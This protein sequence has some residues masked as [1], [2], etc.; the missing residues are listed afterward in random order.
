M[1]AIAIYLLL[2]AGFVIHDVNLCVSQIVEVSAYNTILLLS[3]TT[4][5]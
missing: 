3:I 5:L 1:K 2:F 4:K